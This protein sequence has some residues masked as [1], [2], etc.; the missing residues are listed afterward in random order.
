MNRTSGILRPGGPLSVLAFVALCLGLLAVGV[1]KEL[2]LGAIRGYAVMSESGKALKNATVV[3]RPVDADPDAMP[4]TRLARTD[5][6]GRFQFAN[7]V[8]GNY[9]MEAFSRAHALDSYSLYVQEGRTEVVTLE[10][11][12]QGPN[13]Q[14]YANQHVFL[15]NEAPRIEAHGF[16][17]ENELG[18]SIY[19]VP[20]ESVVKAKSLYQVLS[21]LAYSQP[22]FDI[23][24][25]PTVRRIASESRTITERDDEGVFRETVELP[26]L[27]PGLYWVRITSGGE[28]RGTWLAISRIALVTKSAH[29]SVLAYAT[30]L[31][32]GK[33]VQGAKIQL[34]QG[35]AV[36]DTGVVTDGQ[37]VARF[38]VP[39]GDD[40]DRQTMVV[41]TLAESKAFVSLYQYENR[42]SGAA[43]IHVITDRPVYRPGD[44]VQ[45]KG[46]VRMPADPGTGR[47]YALP[48]G[49][50][51]EVE[52][53]DPEGGSIQRTTL[54]VNAH[55]SLHGGFDLVPD[56]VGSYQLICRYR[57][58]EQT[59][60]VP[61][62]A[63]RKPEFRM[64][65]LPE[66]S[67]FPRGDKVRMKVS[68]EFYFG[69]PVAGA[70]LNAMVYRAPRWETNDLG[71]DDG[72]EPDYDEEG[73]YSGEYVGDL[74][75]VTDG[76]GEAVLEFDSR[77]G[78]R[79]G[80]ETLDSILTFEVSGTETGDKYFQGKGQ[81]LVTRGEIGLRAEPDRY[82]VAPGEPIRIA[83]TAVRNED[84]RPAAGET[85]RLEYGFE[86]WSANR[87]QF[88]REGTQT[89]QTDE[90]GVARVDLPTNRL[91][92]FLVKASLR[93]RR[94]NTVRA[95]CYSYVWRDGA[96]QLPGVAPKLQL[97]LDK[98]AYA[99]GERV[100]AVL[101]TDRPGGSALVT[102]EA[103]KVLFSKVVNLRS[104]TSVSIPLDVSAIPNA[105]IAAAYV[106]NKAFL[107]SSKRV[108]V[109]SPSTR[110]V[111]QVTPDRRDYKPRETVAYRIQTTTPDG[112]PVRCEVALGVVDEAV[113]AI[114][115][116][117]SDPVAGFYPTRTNNV[118]T[119]YSFPEL[120]LDGGD[121]SPVNSEIRQNFKDTAYWNPTIVTGSDGEATVNVVLPDDLTSWRATATAVSDATAC[122]KAATNVR[123]RKDLMVRLSAPSVMVQ[124]DDVR[125]T[126]SVTNATGRPLDARVALEG[127]GFAIT[128]ERTR[129]VRCDG[130]APQTVEW[131]VRPLEPGQASLTVAATTGG[132]SDAMRAKVRVKPHGRLRAS[133]A[134]GMLTEP[135]T[136]LRFER[137]PNAQEG[138][139]ELTLTP[140]LGSTMLAAL[141]ELVD[142]PYGCTEQ[143]MSRFMPA[144]VVL[145]TLRDLGMPRP[146]LE[147]KIADV[148]RRS[149]VRLSRF[150][151]YNGGWGWW[152]HDEPDPGMT[153]LVLEGLWRCREAGL[154]ANPRLAERGVQWIQEFLQQPQ[155]KL[156]MEDRAY[157]CYAWILHQSNDASLAALQRVDTAQLN[158]IGWAYQA[159]A[160]KHFRARNAE[161]QAL[162]ETKAMAALQSLWKRA[163]RSGFQ[164]SFEASE[165]DGWYSSYGVEASARALEAIARIRPDDPGIAGIIQYL[166]VARRSDSWTSTRDAAQVLSGLSLFMAKEFARSGGAPTRLTVK[167]G[168]RT[169]GQW[170]VQAGPN[171][172]QPLVLEI[173]WSECPTGANIIEILREGPAT[174]SYGFATS[175]TPFEKEI[176][177]LANNSGLTVDRTY[178]TLAAE[179][180]ED[181]TRR[182][183]PSKNPVASFESGKPVR[184][185]ITLDAKRRFQFV[186]VE[187]P[188][189]SNMR[190]VENVEPEYWSW[191]YSSI[192][193]LD[194]RVALFV[195]DLPPG[196]HVIEIN[197]RAEAPG[198]AVAL[199][200]LAYEMYQPERR[201]SSAATTLEVR[202]R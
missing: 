113:F 11:G 166:L 64:T 119:G 200:A 44:R 29:G 152:E 180:M 138:Q 141:D 181:G 90:E 80:D 164:V 70:R 162:C 160:W 79:E 61:V 187:V 171:S 74:E 109:D 133:Y 195:R 84:Q 103:D 194:D 40:E 57:G 39:E 72:E 124:G 175:Q 73:G 1:T 10:L 85:I 163:N 30:Y 123:S 88:V 201:G 54:D 51:A 177:M 139:V 56:V 131:T 32:T 193:V 59:T 28:S 143:T 6:E 43:R 151:S 21:P 101:R 118:E 55:G 48:S 34:A 95:E 20:F 35:E 196:Q 47:L 107:Q 179:P 191:W 185:R 42:R 114:R 92:S 127:A 132:P 165:S 27:E 129:T 7:V 8:A 126:A 186:L 176:G 178:H 99:P 172:L 149:L 81:A 91:G 25:S 17:Q 89:A 23:D 38:T 145:K 53:K 69:G 108:R 2:P 197:L 173:P 120:Y 189:P 65:V 71:E 87:S 94:G 24:R 135:T 188:T 167:H 58:S 111:V 16:T 157:L 128:G 190:V 102:V 63:Y 36:R 116:D 112:K 159:L 202:S 97:V 148:S 67:F 31:D 82:V 60:Y 142:Y 3:L 68:C 136:V 66:R 192:Q 155:P 62:A 18:L 147:A 5:E 93:D 115:E 77:Q 117:R 146:D 174:P 19:R 182:L 15:P 76:N 137:L 86:D 199:P 98:R 105:T 49:G 154:E 184:C 156:S 83:L 168:N 100:Q 37:G 130:D 150:Q 169:I 52:V 26:K 140:S 22:G 158:A 144:V 134:S 78:E 198:R 50:T 161:E 170:T 183:M 110:L 9:S 4:G 45:F 106:R 153:A 104:T 33:P 46:I 41:A 13:L 125:V 121:K 122:G 75:A 14:L 12:P 96:G